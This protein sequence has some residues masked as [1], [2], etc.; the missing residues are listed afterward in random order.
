MTEPLSHF[1]H[2]HMIGIKGAGMTALAGLLTKQ[3]ALVTGSDIGEVFFTDRIL[4]DLKIKCVE[5]FDPQNI[6]AATQAIIYSTAYSQEANPELAAA[7]ASGLPVWSYPEALGMLTREKL[8]LAVCGTHGKTTTSALLA[9][10]L[11]F[12][13]LD[14]S[15]IVGS[16]IM[17]WDGNALS[18]SGEYLVLEADE[19][20]N[21]LAAY[22]PFAVILTS[23]DWDHPDFFPD[24]E[25]YERA[26]ADF[27]ERIPR[28]GVL[29]YCS[30]SAR[31]ARI[32]E[33]AM[34]RKISYGLLA[35]ADF[36]I[37]DYVPVKM[38]FVGEADIIKQSFAVTHDGQELGTFKL[39]LAGE[40]NAANATAVLAL[41]LYLKQD[42]ARI[43]TAFEKF[44]GTER[45]FEYIGERYGALFY[46]D[47]AHHPE[48]IRVT[49]KAFRE[50]YPDRRLRV[51]FH[52]HTFTRTKALLT[53][54][55]QS[56]ETADEVAVL[57]IYGSAREVQ[58]GVSSEDLVQLINRFFPGK[59]EYAP[60][61]EE[62]IGRLEETMGRQ[63]VIITLGAGN[64][65][66]IAHRLAKR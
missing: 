9:E 30:D 15:A 3:G 54:F 16:R 29:V 41:A 35:G 52:P 1:K 25:S 20:Q 4:E 11:K 64:V 12:T 58:G 36:H 26:F 28:H 45:R 65:W 56:F 21:K 13:G 33:Q 42:L 32:A 6:P 39:K 5:R 8:T 48:E 66:E 49:L 31:V 46:D 37:H 60:S 23:V 57:D 55:A 18:G 40:H 2:V 17:N 22:A 59:A 27:V 62:L 19:Y 34:C 47:Y 61:Q 7:L 63:D 50:L 43:R 14:P 51:I 38:G 10:T 24:K 44:S 53:D